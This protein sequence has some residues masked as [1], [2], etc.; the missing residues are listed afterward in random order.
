MTGIK[1]KYE[2]KIIIDPPMAGKVG[3]AGKYAEGKEVQ[4]YVTAFGGW[5]FL[6]WSGD[7][8]HSKP[9]F[10]II[11]DKNI[12]I[13]AQFKKVAK[14]ID[15]LTLLTGFILLL[16]I[17]NIIF[18]Y[19]IIE[20]IYSNEE[21]TGF[22]IVSQSESLNQKIELLKVEQSK[23]EKK[24][25]LLAS[26]QSGINEKIDNSIY[27]QKAATDRLSSLANANVDY[28][29]WTGEITTSQTSNSYSMYIGA[30]KNVQ[31]YLSGMT[32]DADLQVFFNPNNSQIA[33]SGRSRPVPEYVDFT[34]S[35]AGNYTFKVFYQPTKY[36]L[37]VYVRN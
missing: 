17:A 19:M 12:T 10:S 6:G 35:L 33:S 27:D 24:V 31:V 36:K 7:I 18:L 11:V 15:K 26:G 14:S 30:S 22:T 1:P 32:N 28:K 37:E 8:S 25:E 2:L 20:K 16:S 4:I 5:E 9:N 34:T 23:L 13:T 21:R 29:V 3:G